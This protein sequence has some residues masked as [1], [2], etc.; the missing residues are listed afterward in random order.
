MPTIGWSQFALDRHKPGTGHSYSTLSNEEVTELVHTHWERRQP[1]QGE[2]GLDRK[3]VVPVPPQ[4]FRCTTVKIFEAMPLDAQVTRRQP[5]EDFYVEV[6]T[7]VWRPK[8]GWMIETESVNFASVVLYNKD[9]LVEN[10][11]KRSTDADWEIVCL[12][13]SPVEKEPMHPLVM[14]RNMLE[15]PGGTKSTYTAQEFAEAIYYWSQRV[16]TKG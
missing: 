11:G 12:L 1:G 2:T 9:T 14:A 15:K 6:S 16:K 7:P 10:G 3:V 8:P 4:S 5:H 13:A